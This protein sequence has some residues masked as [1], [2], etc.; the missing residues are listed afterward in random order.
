MIIKGVI[1]YAYIR[2]CDDL[3]AKIND[4]KVKC[5]EK[6]PTEKEM[7]EVYNVSISTVRKAMYYLRD[8]GLIYSKRGSG[9]YVAKKQPGNTN[10]QQPSL[11]QQGTSNNVATKIISFQIRR[12]NLQEAKNL[13]IKANARVYEIV[14]ER[15]INQQLY[16]IEINLIPVALIPNLDV[17]Q[18]KRSLNKVYTDNQIKR[19]KVKN[20][21]MWFEQSTIEQFKLTTVEEQT[22][23]FNI[24]R[25]LEL[26]NGGVVE[27]SRILIFDD[28]LNF[29]YIHVY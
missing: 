2:I 13:K 19:I 25:K 14:R 9:Y 16:M 5:D 23:K 18:A 1:M 20:K 28:H 21:L 12:A 4:G 22:V 3:T 7:C 11:S 15:Y 8:K 29:E 6:L 26:L 27:Y 10:L 24:E 17:D